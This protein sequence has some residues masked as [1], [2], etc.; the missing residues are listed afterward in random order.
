MVD[1]NIEKI[2]DYVDKVLVLHEGEVVAYDEPHV[3]FRNKKMLND[4][5][6][7]IPQVTEA[8]IGMSE[9]LGELENFPIRLDEAEKMF[10]KIVKEER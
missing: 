2:A 10:E 4:H 5:F 9:E 7:R 8:A 6:V 3:V 1:H